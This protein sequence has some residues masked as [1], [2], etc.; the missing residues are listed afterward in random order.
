MDCSPPGSSVHR[1]SSQEYWSRLPFPS[2]GGLPDPGIQPRSLALQADSLPFEPPGFSEEV[3]F[4]QRPEGKGEFQVVKNLPTNAGDTK[5]MGS[6]PRSER[7]PGAG[8]GNLLQYSCWENPM[9]RGDWQ[10]TIHGVQRVRHKGHAWMFIQKGRRKIFGE[11]LPGR[12]HSL[13][14]GP[15][16][17]LCLKKHPRDPWVYSKLSVEESWRRRGLGGDSADRAYPGGP[18]ERS[19]DRLNA[20]WEKEKSWVTPEFLAWAHLDWNFQWRMRKKLF[21]FRSCI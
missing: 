3:T 7:F 8:N 10:A 2:L 6:T 12:G 14:K 18:L 5:D 13:C 1:F 16:G 15:E 11:S 21:S 17:G 4:K 19:A 20:V 9:G